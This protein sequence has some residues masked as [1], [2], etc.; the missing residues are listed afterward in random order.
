L[1]DYQELRQRAEKLDWRDN[2]YDHYLLHFIESTKV[3]LPGPSRGFELFQNRSSPC[4][5]GNG[6]ASFLVLR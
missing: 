5:R 2:P 1:R 6:F 4:W 3:D